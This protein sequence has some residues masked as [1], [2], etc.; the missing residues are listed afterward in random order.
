MRG[1]VLW[2][3]VKKVQGKKKT[4]KKQKS[5]GGHDQIVLNFFFCESFL[6]SKEL[7]KEEA[8][9]FAFRDD[10]AWQINNGL[11]HDA[12]FLYLPKQFADST[13]PVSASQFSVSTSTLFPIKEEKTR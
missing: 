7:S 3:K 12:V 11:N 5:F 8:N 6:V 13:K 10:S 9:C 2:D 4:K 1:W